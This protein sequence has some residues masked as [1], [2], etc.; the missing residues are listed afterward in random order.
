[1]PEMLR[2]CKV[3]VPAANFGQGLATRCEVEQIAGYR[4]SSYNGQPWIRDGNMTIMF[5]MYVGNGLN[6]QNVILS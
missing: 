2:Q 1:M 4:H 5:V 6:S 3:D